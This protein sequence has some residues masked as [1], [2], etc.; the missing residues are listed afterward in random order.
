MASKDEL[1]NSLK[2][3]YG[4][5]KNISQSLAKEECERLLDV[6]NHEPSTVKLI[7]SFAQ[8]NSNLGKNNAYFSR[9]RSQAE[10]KLES[11]QKEHQDLEKSIKTLEDSKQELENK[12]KQLENERIELEADIKSLSLENNS[13]AS[14]VQNLTSQ[15]DELIDA[16]EQLKKDNKD[17]KNIVD[18]IRLRLARDTKLLL[19]YEDSEIKKA[20]IRLFSWTLG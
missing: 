2:E 11:L 10:K 1:Q 17:L 5:N 19:K 14:K 12:K 7:E 18:Q 6:L 16:N 3:K 9:M 8:K 4:I 15:N 13:L 20:L